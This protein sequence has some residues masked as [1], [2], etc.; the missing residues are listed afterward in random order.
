MPT[1]LDLILSHRCF[2][3]QIYLY[4]KIYLTS[5]HK[6]TECLASSTLTESVILIYRKTTNIAV[7]VTF[8]VKV[9]Q[10]VS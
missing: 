2:A 3:D 7:S 5:I 4:P 9:Y 1:T 10:S 6:H 8:S